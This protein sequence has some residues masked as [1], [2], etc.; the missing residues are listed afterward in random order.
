RADGRRRRWP[1]H[2]A[3]LLR[4][5]ARRLVYREHQGG[6]VPH[7]DHASRT[8]VVGGLLQDRACRPPNNLT[9]GP[10]TIGCT[11]TARYPDVPVSQG[12]PPAG[13]TLGQAPVQPRARVPLA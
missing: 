9:S 12:S 6:G 4:R 13:R 3:P 8:L 5:R 1:A 2:G 10:I 11:A 7:L